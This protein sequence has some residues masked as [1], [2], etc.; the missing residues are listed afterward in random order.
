MRSFGRKVSDRYVYPYTARPAVGP[1]GVVPATVHAEQDAVTETRVE[2]VL[3]QVDV[4]HVGVRRVT[5]WHG[6]PDLVELHPRTSA[7]QF[8]AQAPEAFRVGI[9]QEFNVGV[10]PDE[11]LGRVA[12]P[13][14]DVQRVAGHDPARGYGSRWWRR[15]L[16]LR[17]QRHAST[18]VRVR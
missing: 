11:A 15:S 14:H 9:S 6:E 17:E 10:Y 2:H 18:Y 4:H 16:R 3:N 13:F 8:L 12:R 5:S 1:S 7:R